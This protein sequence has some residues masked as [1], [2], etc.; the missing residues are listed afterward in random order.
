MNFFATALVKFGLNADI[1]GDVLLFDNDNTQITKDIFQI[2]APQFIRCPHFGLKMGLKSDTNEPFIVQV[3][4][5]IM[6]II[7]LNLQQ[8]ISFLSRN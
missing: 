6:T 3:L 8:K 4:F 2:I 5:S 7:L 1:M